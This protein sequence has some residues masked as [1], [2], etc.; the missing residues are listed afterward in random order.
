MTKVVKI[1]SPSEFT[2]DISWILD[3]E[4]QPRQLPPPPPGVGPGYMAGQTYEFELDGVEESKRLRDGNH[5]I[6]LKDEAKDGWAGGMNLIWTAT[7]GTCDYENDG[8]CDAGTF[9][10]AAG[11]DVCDCGRCTSSSLGLF[12]K[13]ERLMATY[14]LAP[15]ATAAECFAAL[16]RMSGV[17]EVVRRDPVT[18]IDRTISKGFVGF[19]TW[20]KLKIDFACGAPATCA[21]SELAVGECKCS[22]ECSFSEC[23]RAPRFGVAGPDVYPVWLADVQCDGTE[24]SLCQ[25]AHGFKATKTMTA[26]GHGQNPAANLLKGQHSEYVVPGCGNSHVYDAGVV[27][28]GAALRDTGTDP[29]FKV[30]V[31]RVQ[32]CLGSCVDSTLLG[33]GWC[34]AGQRGAKFN[35]DALKC[36][37]GDCDLDS[38]CTADA[39]QCGAGQLQCGDKSCKPGSARCNDIDDC[40][41]KSDEAECKPRS[42]WF[43]CPSEPASPIPRSLV[44]NGRRDCTDGADES[45]AAAIFDNFAYNMDQLSCRSVLTRPGLTLWH[46]DPAST[47]HLA[48]AVRPPL[49]IHIPFGIPGG[50]SRP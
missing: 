44:N 5:S 7:N 4:L 48:S 12:N 34:D 25:C 13:T 40:A 32:D 29:V 9:E 36:D 6:W 15:C 19:G 22:Q 11:T 42:E 37:F 18:R 46:P 49:G 30:P 3:E 28:L 16:A 39:P 10:C 47:Y 17:W 43:Y 1:T 31:P 8:Q 20:E 24:S 23:T 21:E 2:Q 45:T 14:G 38:S 27:C 50:G 33:D 35:C 41:D 26:W